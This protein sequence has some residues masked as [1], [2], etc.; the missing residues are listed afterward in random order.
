MRRLLP[1]LVVVW[2]AFSAVTTVV[3]SADAAPPPASVLINAS[4]LLRL[5][6]IESPALSPDGKWVVYVVRSIEPKP[7]VPA[8]AAAK[9]G[10]KSDWVYHTNLWLAATDGKTPPRQLTRNANS[11][12]A[13]AWSPDGSRIAF[14]RG[15]NAPT[16]KAQLYLLTLDGGEAQQLTKSEFGAG[17]PHWSPD[18]TKILFSA[19][20][21]Y[22]QV[23]DALEKAG[24]DA[25]P[26]WNF[27]K[28][29]RTANDTKNYGLK[30]KGAEAAKPEPDLSAATLAK[31]D[32]TMQERREW[33]AQNEADGNPRPLDRLSFLSETDIN[34]EMTFAHLFVQEAREGAEAKDLTPGYNG[35]VGGDWLR[36]GKSI[37][38]TGAKNLLDHPDR[39][40]TTSLYQVD[41][42]DGGVKLFL[43]MK[44]YSLGNAVVS[45]DGKSVAFT[46]TPG[47]FLG[48]GQAAVAVCT[49]TGAD[50]K[51]LTAKLDRA[52]GNLRWSHDSRHIYFV[53][54]TNGGFPLYQVG[55][56]GSDAERVT[57]FDS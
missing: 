26:K 40:T 20:L 7:D 52:A 47:E 57:P 22:A 54:P 56:D 34:P 53:A 12:T 43:E 55:L 46:A 39:V 44:E 9:A 33:L 14:V 48:F 32:G 5:K 41:A 8:E 4:D 38:C 29:G 50:A 51:L 23:R 16:D 24:V 13:P 1:R 35:F 30:Q 18:G 25:K 36:D 31:A 21:N 42:A 17:A 49:V 19:P 3:R 28:P 15:G 6:Q 37:V 45:P 11:N 2:L 10:A 27:E